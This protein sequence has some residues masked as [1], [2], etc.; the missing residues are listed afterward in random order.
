MI[1]KHGGHILR[2]MFEVCGLCF[3]DSAF[4]VLIGWAGKLITWTNVLPSLP[5]FLDGL[6]S[7]RLTF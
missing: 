4:R 6:A 1:I 7:R 2:E 5:C 3:P